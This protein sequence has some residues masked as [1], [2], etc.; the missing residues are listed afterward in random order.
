MADHSRV[1][2]TVFSARQLA[3]C[4]TF[5]LRL[6]V[7][8][9]LVEFEVPLRID[10]LP[11]R[12]AEQLQCSAWS[13][14]RHGSCRLAAADLGR[15][16]L[17]LLKFALTLLDESLG[18]VRCIFK[19][20]LGGLLLSERDLGIEIRESTT[21]KAI[22]MLLAFI[23]E[24]RTL[25]PLVTCKAACH[26]QREPFA[27]V[28]LIDVAGLGINLFRLLH[29]AAAVAVVAVVVVV[30][31][32]EGG[33]A[34]CGGG[35]YCSCAWHYYPTKFALDARDMFGC[36][37]RPAG[38]TAG[39]ITGNPEVARSATTTVLGKGKN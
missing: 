38:G 36:A 35:C 28:V 15:Q 33:G 21:G 4:L 13:W 23:A 32:V 16:R 14:L 11:L 22:V 10:H 7:K 29:L 19:P 3:A 37:V 30:V 24:L 8:L 6:Q 5:S 18:C 34:G 26:A 27:R 25:D 17:D 12:N 1:Q 39:G 2:Q 31:V 9:L 20:F